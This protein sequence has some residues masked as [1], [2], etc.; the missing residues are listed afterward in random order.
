MTTKNNELFKGVEFIDEV[1]PQPGETIDTNEIEIPDVKTPPAKAEDDDDDDL[2]HTKDITKETEEEIPGQS[3]SPFSSLATAFAARDLIPSDNKEMM[4]AFGEV[5]DMQGFLDLFEKHRIDTIDKNFNERQK[6][7]IDALANGVPKKEFEEYQS[8]MDTLNGITDDVLTKNEK[9]RTAVAQDYYAAKGITDADEV[10]ALVSAAL[11]KGES[12]IKGMR[13]ELKKTYTNLYNQS[14][15]KYKSEADAEY[16]QESDNLEKIT[17]YIKEKELF[18]GLKLSDQLMDRVTKAATKIVNNDEKRP[19]TALMKEMKEKPIETNAKLAYIWEM[20]KGL[21]TLKGFNSKAMT[22]AT[23]AVEQLSQ[24]QLMGTTFL[25]T[26]E[27]DKNVK[28]K[29]KALTNIISMVVD[30]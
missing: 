17:T 7:Y 26:P 3:S 18:P 12:H 23:R 6:A 21:T 27:A 8:V 10:N 13:D 30:D 28:Q 4:T 11:T 2:D 19:M 1:N 5:K 20:T 14:V 25:D 29:A 16:V 22:E 9:V 24:S 15:E